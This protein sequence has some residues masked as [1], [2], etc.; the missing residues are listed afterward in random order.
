LVERKVC[1]IL[2]A[3][4]LEDDLCPKTDSHHPSPPRPQYSVGKSFERGV[5]VVYR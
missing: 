4:W 3:R 5:S 2:E 1:F